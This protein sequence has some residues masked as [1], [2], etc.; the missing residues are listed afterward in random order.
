MSCESILALFALDG[1]P[2]L[3]GMADGA[4]LSS[5]RSDIPGSLAT[6]SADARNWLIAVSSLGGK[7]AMALLCIICSAFPGCRPSTLLGG[8][9][10]SP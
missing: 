7:G 1:S 6:C 10:N 5:L 2:V 4:M 8:G 3:Y 9:G